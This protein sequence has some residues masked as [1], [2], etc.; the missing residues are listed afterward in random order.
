MFGLFSK[1]FMIFPRSLVIAS[2]LISHSE[3]HIV[4]S[5]VG[6]VIKETDL[7]YINVS[8]GRC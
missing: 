6:Y 8:L 5:E 2:L 1:E 3:D 4:S 7:L